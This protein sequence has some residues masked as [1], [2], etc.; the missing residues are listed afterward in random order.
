M[1]K[2]SVVYHQY[3][4][5]IEMVIEPEGEPHTRY[6]GALA[7]Q[8][9]WERFGV[10]ELLTKAGIHYGQEL[11]RAAEMSLAL[12][13]GPLVEAHSTLKV[14]QRFGGEASDLEKD[15]LLTHMIDQPFDQRTLARFAPHERHRWE[16][17]N[18]ERVAQLQHEPAFQ[19]SRKGVVILD[20]FPLPKPH[21]RKM[22]YLSP[23][24]D[25]S[26]KRT[27]MGYSIV[28]LYYYHP[29]RPGYSLYMEPW[30]KTSATGETQAKSGR[31]RA[32]EGEELS[33]LDLGLQA[34]ER[35]LSQFPHFQAVVMD[36][37]YTARWLC[38]ELTALG[39]A[40]IGEAS[41]NRH[42][43]IHNKEL[44]V[45]QIW[46]RYGS[47]LKPLPK[48]NPKEVR[49]Y[50]LD[51]RIPP[52]RY[53]PEPQPVTLILTEGLHKPRDKDAGRHLL[54]ANRRQWSTKKLVRLFAYRPQIEPVHR[55][56]KQDQG[57]LDF[58]TQKFEGLLCHLA[59]SLIRHTLLRL[60]QV[61]EPK[62]AHY[63]LQQLIAHWIGT[64]ADL[65]FDRSGQLRLHLAR[66][67]PAL[68]LILGSDP[69]PLVSGS[70]FE[71]HS[72]RSPAFVVPLSYV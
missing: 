23:I 33:R 70:L 64:V 16:I 1:P 48:F 45:P 12:S 44:S 10:A 39:L 22:A 5:Q 43:L 8:Q 14:A 37:W 62:L 25:N 56:D 18:W 27:V 15:E 29:H 34:I 3:S 7:Y 67:H 13:L 65:S 28:H 26:L 47:Q 2:E 71:L 6:G 59:L 50:R 38:A 52:D 49:V 63:S 53:T 58:H 31:R 17:L 21:A 19:M 42:F 40:W 72:F 41:L 68:S 69:P 55:Q 4:D 61:W 30:R 60:M 57:W 51:A 35:V 36:S 46:Q 11:D 54:V 20:D 32:K 24:R 66:D 9:A